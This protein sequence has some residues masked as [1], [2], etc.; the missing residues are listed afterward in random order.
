MMAL[1]ARLVSALVGRAPA[2]T[3]DIRWPDGRASRLGGAAP[4]P[5]AAIDF[6]AWR[7]V[8]RGVFGGALGLAE[9]YLDGEWDSPDLAALVEFGARARLVGDLAHRPLLPRRLFDRLAHRRR[10]NTRPGSRRNIAAHYDLGNAFYGLWLDPTLTYSSAV[11]ARPDQSLDEAQ[12]EKCRRLL[13][14]LAPRPGQ[15]LL[16]I[17]C[18]WG[19]FARVAAKEAGVSVTAITLSREQHEFARRRMFEEGLAEKV[20]VELRDYRDVSERFDHVASVEM[21]E[22]VGEEY[23]P[24]FFGKLAGVLAPD[25]RAALQIITIDDAL[26]PRYRRGV[27]FIQKYIFPGG[28]LPS[29]A[30]IE[31]VS[32]RAG[33]AWQ[34]AAGFGQ[35]YA[36]TLAEWRRR[37]LAAWPP[38]SALGFD[39]RFRRMWTYYL[40][41]CEGGFRAGNID[42]KQIALA[43]S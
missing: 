27:D 13:A 21:F 29:L 24:A 11:F 34:G 5:A 25:G 6:K 41:Y 22:A 43:K 37:F 3:L 36:R 39:E 28:V 17:G 23:W 38:I 32:R 1:R 18:G 14:L 19:H 4:G 2:G 10:A 33:L 8:R 26:F 20:S 35:H 12:T 31:A 7:A 30:A 16:E 9:A 15:R 40:A 42:V